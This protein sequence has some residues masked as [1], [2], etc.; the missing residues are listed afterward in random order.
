MSEAVLPPPLDRFWAAVNNGDSPG[1][2]DFFG[3]DGVVNDWGREFKGRHE[4][5]GWN[6][7]EFIGV[8]MRFD[9]HNV[10]QRGSE[11]VVTGQVTSDGFN[12]PSTFTFVLDGDQIKL[13]RITA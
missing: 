8:N 12:G 4:I 6:D 7:R 11:T 5:S 1:F 13:M 10:E 9:A 3:A 2:L